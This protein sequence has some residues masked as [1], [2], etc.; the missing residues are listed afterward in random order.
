MLGS[1]KMLSGAE[2]IVLRSH[3]PGVT[4]GSLVG[5]PCC[6]DVGAAF[7]LVVLLKPNCSLYNI[8]KMIT[9]QSVFDL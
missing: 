5:H 2:R 6:E 4:Q 3:V 9:D 8:D 7:M 1:S